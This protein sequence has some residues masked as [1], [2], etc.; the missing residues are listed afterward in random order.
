M[1]ILD[2][3]KEH[4]IISALVFGLVLLFLLISGGEQKQNNNSGSKIEQIKTNTV[5]GEQ[6]TIVDSSNINT[7]DNNNNNNN[8]S[9]T[10]TAINSTQTEL[11][12]PTIKPELP[13]PTDLGPNYQLEPFLPYVGEN[14]TISQYLAPLVLEVDIK[15]KND[16]TKAEV[17]VKEWLLENEFNQGQHKIIWKIVE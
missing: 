8:L 16:I 1:K 12:S 7:E 6:Q 15:N 5:E 9:P 2:L 17:L 10:K 14:F 13:D 11:P 3:I 4:K